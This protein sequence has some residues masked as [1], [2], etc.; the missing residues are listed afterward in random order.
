MCFALL[1]PQLNEMSEIVEDIAEHRK[2]IERIEELL[3]P[4]KVTPRKNH[5]PLRTPPALRTPPPLLALQDNSDAE[6]IKM[7]SPNTSPDRKVGRAW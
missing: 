6:D 4:K 1:L 7:D 5:S 3:T 2:Q